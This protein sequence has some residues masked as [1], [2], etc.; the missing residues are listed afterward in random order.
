MDSGRA[1]IAHLKEQIERSRRIVFFGGAGV[2][3]ES[4]IPDFRSESGV[5]S[6]AQEYGATPEELLGY[7]C[8]KGRPELFFSYY[9]RFLVH[10]NAK[11]NPAHLALASL[12]NL[13][14]LRAVVTQN[15]DGL[16]QAAGSKTVHELH[17][18]MHRNYCMDCRAEYPLRFIMDAANC[19]GAVP[20]CEKC[21]GTVRPD[22]VLYGEPL[23]ERVVNASLSA[24]SE[25][26]M[27]IVGGTSLAVYP[28]AGLLRH[29]GGGCIAQINKSETP[30]D[31]SADITIRM[32][33]GQVLGEVCGL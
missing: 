25:A 5:F 26:D 18:S 12:E 17:G 1:G 4:G 19:R 28:A 30:L 32:P 23:S 11:P 33:I 15:I 14:R 31:S 13:G 27:I 16:H 8:L 22:V 10:E 6:A 24:I 3:T 9:K 7:G 20:V 2:S 21:G 29:F